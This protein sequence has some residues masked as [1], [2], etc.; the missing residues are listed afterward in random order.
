M[1]GK[2][3]RDLFLLLTNYADVEVFLLAVFYR[4]HVLLVQ[5]ALE[6]IAHELP[7][8]AVP[9]CIASLRPL[10]PVL[11]SCRRR[12]RCMDYRTCNGNSVHHNRVGPQ[13]SGPR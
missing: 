7:F 12:Q 13:A 3:P 8:G 9:C 11:L 1:W 5:L 4:L 6:L 10:V 2:S